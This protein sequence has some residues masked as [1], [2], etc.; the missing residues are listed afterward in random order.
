MSNY[1]VEAKFAG[2]TLNNPAESLVDTL[3]QAW[4]RVIELSTVHDAPGTRLIVTDRAGEV[5]IAIGVLTA[6]KM[7]ALEA[8]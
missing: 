7:Q 4:D 2:R 1:L 3:D 5:V 8:A 6:R